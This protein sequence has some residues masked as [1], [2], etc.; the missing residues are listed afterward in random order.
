MLMSEIDIITDGGRRRRWS[1]TDKAMWEAGAAAQVMPPAA[2]KIYRSARPVTL[3]AY[4]GH[5]VVRGF[6]GKINGKVAG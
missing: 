2:E 4:G 1:A 3:V 6:N 5:R